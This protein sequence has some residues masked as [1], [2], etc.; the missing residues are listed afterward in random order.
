M[1]TI[2]YPNSFVRTITVD[3]HPLVFR[4]VKE[5]QPAICYGVHCINDKAMPVFIFT[6][7]GDSWTAFSDIPIQH[8]LLGNR[9]ATL[10]SLATG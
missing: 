6:L 4:F 3:G 9:L 1:S 5:D 10:L 2:H 8:T 7:T